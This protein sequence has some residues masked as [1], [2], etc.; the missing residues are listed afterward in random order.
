MC[1]LTLI[2]PASHYRIT[3]QTLGLIRFFRQSGVGFLILDWSER[4]IWPNDLVVCRVYRQDLNVT[5]WIGGSLMLNPVVWK[6]Q[7]LKSEVLTNNSQWEWADHSHKPGLVTNQTG[8]M[9]LMWQDS[10]CVTHVTLSPAC[11]IPSPWITTLKLCSMNT[12]C[13]V[14]HVDWIVWCVCAYN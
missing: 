13:V 2:N 8:P 5:D 12:K 4:V 9:S 1:C 6:E 3:G 14:L 10:C 7:W 11:G